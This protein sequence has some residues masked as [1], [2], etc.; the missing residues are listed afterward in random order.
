MTKRQ[1]SVAE[2][3]PLYDGL[4]EK[5]RLARERFMRPLT[6]AE[7]ILTA[8]LDR[9][10][11]GETH[12]VRGSS[13][14]FLRPDRVAMQDATA[15][16]ALLQ[17]MQ[18]N[19]DKVYVPTTVHCD[20]LIQARVGARLD[21]LNA[22]DTNSEV[23]DFLK[24][25]ATK[26]GAGFWKPG[27]GIIHQVVLENYAFPGSLLIGTDSHTPN[28]GGLGML[29]IGVGGADATFTMAGEPWGLRWPKL[30]G[31]KLTGALNGWASPKD[32][33]LKLAGIL[34]VDGGTGSIVE[35]FG[36]GTK[37][38]SATG[39]A[40]I[41]NMGAELGATTSVFPLDEHILAYL[42]LTGRGE[43]A[44]LAQSRSQ[45][46]TAD[47][48]VE[49]D[50]HAYFDRVIEIDLD[51]LEPHIVG[52]HTPDLARPISEFVAEV[53]AKGYPADLRY[54]L[55]GSCTNS[56]YEDM[57]RAAAVARQASARGVKAAVGFMVTPGSEQVHQTINRDGQMSDL[58]AIGAN[59]LA[60]ACG[61]CIGQWKRDDIKDG[62]AN[63]I[64]TSF[65]R[66]FPRRNDGNAET[67]AFIA[68]PE[69]VTAFA[70]KGSLAFNPLTDSLTAAD[71]SQF[72]LD[73][74]PAA[75]L[76]E[77]GF[78]EVD[79]G[80]VDA[81]TAD[82]AA[83]D[84]AIKSDSQR[85]QVLVPFSRWDGN[86][87][88][89]L[90][91]LLKAKGK[92]T[93]DHISPAGPWL[94]YR[95]HLDRISDNMFLGANNAFAP[96]PGTGINVLTG[97]TDKLTTVARQYKA[98]GMG[99]VVVGD[100]NYGEGSSREHAAM[101]PRFLGCRVVI[102]RSFAR[103]H[104][105]NLKQQGVLALTFADAA[106]YDR[107]G[108]ADRVSVEGL[109]KLA[110]GVSVDVVITHEDGSVDRVSAK[111]TMTEEQVEWFKTGSALNLV[112]D[113]RKQ[114]AQ[115][116]AGTAGMPDGDCDAH[117]QDCP[118][119]D[120][121]CDARDQ[122]CDRNGGG[123]RGDDPDGTGDERDTRGE[124]EQLD[125][126]WEPVRVEPAIEKVERPAVEPV[127]DEPVAHEHDED[128]C[129]ATACSARPPW[130]VRL[131]RWITSFGARS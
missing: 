87:F 25:A 109:A 127:R 39:K 69:I 50:P 92:C 76:P 118:R 130:W 13:Y 4:P 24:S 112:H 45:F 119:R 56:S 80:Y 61:P 110:P 117:D 125:A 11:E 93:T 107:I 131:W 55:I 54:A 44:D 82:G 89:A 34:T 84:V 29:A 1:T 63:S 113:R 51:K 42:R 77:K 111:H 36:P 32:I 83:T 64:I 40:T 2:V 7:K 10:N 68:S 105:T 123:G 106:D 100:Q 9:W 91:V 124:P 37:T 52:P 27:S 65:N 20:H 72:K 116:Q 129:S 104:E 95:G 101:S 28:A 31:V 59:V 121:D 103:I 94:K 3:T 22:L 57:S 21:L 98:A 30:I 47:P 60:N 126:V 17:F 16:M 75:G 41:T 18:A 122:D 108:A 19:L 5:Y 86:D 96:A 62:E 102:A 115:K 114:E 33:I 46:L 23:Y 81:G 66:N 8:H 71:G 79:F 6:L 120:D 58:E 12:P 128:G 90:P 43:I 35:Y 88:R 85:L 73:P 70:L 38:I 15:Q 48:E 97:V 26:Y 53:A 74:P 78:S 99:W 67:L 14:V 49:A